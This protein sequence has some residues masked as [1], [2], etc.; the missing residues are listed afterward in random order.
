VGPGQPTF[1]FAVAFDAQ[2]RMILTVDAYGNTFDERVYYYANPVPTCNQQGGC[3]VPAR[4]IFGSTNA[5][6]ASVSFDS[7]GNLAVLD[8]TWNRVLYYKAAD[9]TAWLA[10][11]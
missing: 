1:P 2:N 10:A 5:Q 11:H 8:H 3:A 6:P 9:V 7:A 4:A